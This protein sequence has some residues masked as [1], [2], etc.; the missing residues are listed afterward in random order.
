MHERS[1]DPHPGTSQASHPYVFGTSPDRATEELTR[2]A[3]QDRAITRAYGIVPSA[4]V[5]PAPT[6][7]ILD[8]ACGTGGWL[9][10]ATQRFQAQGLQLARGIDKDPAM[11]AFAR[12]QARVRQIEHLVTFE[13][14]D[15]LT[16]LGHAAEDGPYDLIHSRFIAAFLPAAG[17][18]A[19]ARTCK[20]LL[21]P[22]GVLLL[23]ESELATTNSAAYNRL[24]QIFLRALQQTGMNFGGEMCW[25]VTARLR[26]FLREA[27]FSSI[28]VQSH[29]LEFSAG[30]A[31]HEMVFK[32]F[33]LGLHTARPFLL[34]YGRISEEEYEAALQQLWHDF[35][36]DDFSA[37]GYSLSAWGIA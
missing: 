9:L 5:L 1:N 10:E 25:G 24:S 3:L 19:L 32:D 14:G 37:V 21:K 2:L 30:T 36:S 23:C 12:A 18:P 27:G 33:Q 20:A 35:Q 13:E 7:R 8:L 31:H 11:V 26:A 22:G 17:W 16:D 6:S 15:I 29:V 34:T 28:Q 4:L